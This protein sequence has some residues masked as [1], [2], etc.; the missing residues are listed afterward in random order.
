MTATHGPNR[1][2]QPSRDELE[3]QLRDES[4]EEPRWWS[5][6]FHLGD[7]DVELSPGD[8]LDIEPETEHAATVGPQGVTCVEAARRS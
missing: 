5:N 3:R 4:D 6:L 2:E 8:R 7:G 1:G